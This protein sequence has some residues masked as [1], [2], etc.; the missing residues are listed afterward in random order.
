M[1]LS[2]KNGTNVQAHPIDGNH[3]GICRMACPTCRGLV[4]KH[5]ES[6]LLVLFWK[7][8]STMTVSCAGFDVKKTTKRLN[9]KITDEPL[10][11]S[12]NHNN[13]ACKYISC[14]LATLHVLDMNQATDNNS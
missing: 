6:S 14:C 10:E 3:S 13:D 7:D 11:N 5:T 1:I 8:D 12:K 2:Y 9:R 4:Q